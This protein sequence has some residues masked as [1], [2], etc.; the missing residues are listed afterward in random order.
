M[1]TPE[2]LRVAF[3]FSLGINLLASAYLWTVAQ[4]ERPNLRRLVLALVV[5]SMF[6][7]VLML[8]SLN[9]IVRGAWPPNDS[10]RISALAFCLVIPACQLLLYSLF[11]GIQ[12]IQKRST[13]SQ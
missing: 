8:Q 6:L 4:M 5:S 13:N 12:T 3:Y 7:E 1:I 10:K 2:L 11:R 9:M